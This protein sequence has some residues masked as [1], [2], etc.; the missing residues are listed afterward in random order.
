MRGASSS[1]TPWHSREPDEVL[2][3]LAASEQGLSGEQVAERLARHGENRLP[4]PPRSG[5]LRRFLRQFH[6]VLIYVLLA[7]ALGT[8]LLQHWVDTGVILGV[9]VINAI[10]GFLQE[11]KAEQALEAIRGMLSPKALVLRDGQ[12]RTVP[13]E[14]LVPGDL[15]FLQAGD[16]VPADLRLLRCHNLRLDEA[17]LTGESVA[18][19]KQIDAVDADADLGDRR[20]MAFSGTLVAFGQGRGVVVGTG[21]ATEIGRISTLLGEVETLTTPLLREIATFGRW[22]SGAIV[23]LA[24]MTFAFGYWGRHYDLLETFLA[25]VSLAVAAIPEGL[26]AIMTITLAIGVQRM[27]VRNAI[28]RRLPAVETLGSVTTI[29]TDKTGTL[30]RNEMTVKT[31]LTAEESYEVSGVGYAPHGGIHHAGEEVALEQHPVLA[32]ALRAILLCNDAEL[33]RRDGGWHLE[34]DPTEGALV[35]AGLKAGLDAREVARHYPRDDVIPFESLYKFMVTLHHHHEGGQRLLF[36]KGAPERV[37]AVCDRERTRDGDRP[38]DRPRW[39]QRMDAIAARGQRLLAVALKPMDEERRTLA[40]PDVE[41]GGLTLVAVCGIIDPPREEAI[42]AVRQCQQAGIVVKMITG[43]HA[44]TARA[45]ADELGI[46]TAGGVVP[47]HVLEPLSDGELEALVREVDVFARATPEHKLRLVRALQAG[48]QVV[49]MTGD[50]VNDAP[51]LKRADVGVAMGIKGSEAAREAAAMVLADDNFASIAHAVEEG[52]TVYDNLRKA[53]LY[54]LPT[55]GGEALTIMA[56]VLLGMTLPLLPAQ[57]LWVNMVTAVTL[58]LALAFE[59]AEPGVMRR[60]PR[61]PG[62]PILSGF[63]VWRAGFVSL[64]L[65][66]GTFGHFLW[67]ERQG[68]EIELARTV[69]INALVMGEI[70][71]LFNS[72]YILE[73]AWNRAGLLG[74][75]AVLFAVGGLVVLQAL[76]TYSAPLQLLFGTAPLGVKEWASILAFGVILFALVELEKALFRRRGRGAPRV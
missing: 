64:L 54:I 63:L 31:L 17:M 50:G 34:G 13:A 1:A 37:L 61:D 39:E 28:I 2:A 19:D 72:R 30:T 68:V 12:R 35:V 24:G 71:Y 40:F 8:A 49:A 62:A 11:G 21:A 57:V 60:R 41:A 29:C 66:A 10:V 32:E 67:M 43:D 15:V 38:L 26:P 46:R 6:N 25:A 18:V 23:V 9:V 75:R 74:S 44:V 14:Q 56:A 65:L 55:S 52:R 53:I 45:I 33:Q 70:A 42:A 48:G 4:A 73:P 36:L 58:S 59:P 16:R 5:P 3:E 7:A 22:L 27:A 76:F 20:G 69:A 47:G 51:A